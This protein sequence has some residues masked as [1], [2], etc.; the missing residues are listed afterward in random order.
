LKGDDVGN[1]K[2]NHDSIVQ[3]GHQPHASQVQRMNS[4]SNGSESKC[5]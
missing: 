4:T 1:R 5:S 3:R 2:R